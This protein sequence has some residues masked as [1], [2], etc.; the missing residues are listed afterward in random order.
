MSSRYMQPLRNIV[1]AAFMIFMFW[2]GLELYR[3]ADAIRTGVF[4]PIR[5][6]GVDGFLPISG[7]LGTAFWF[8]GGEINSI[9]PAAVVIFLTILVVSLLLKRS[10]CSWICPLAT[11]SELA[12]KSGFRFLR[13]NWRL[14]AWLDNV[15]RSFKYLLMAFFLYFIVVTMSVSEQSAF[16]HSDYHKIADVRLL[17][18]FQHLSLAAGIIT[19]LL[20]ALSFVLKNPFCRYLCP[21][22]ALLGL[23]A[24]LSPTRVT[25]NPERCVSCGVCSQVCPAYLDVMHKTSVI[26]PECF[27][28]WRCISHCRC[29]EALAMRAFNKWKLSGSLFAILLIIL[30]LG[31]TLVGKWSGHWHSSIPIDEYVRLLR[32]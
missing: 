2:L 26:S 11:V 31:G 20:L 29:S 18:F 30:F 6:D 12:W 16:I 15:L 14:P 9:H 1:Q 32:R 3:F 7:L 17:Y 13:Y 10:F 24:T 22:G 25:R 5:P 4:V 28:C 8:K 19:G 21:Y 27:A 23:V